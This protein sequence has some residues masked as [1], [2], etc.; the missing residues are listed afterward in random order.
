M[1]RCRCATEKSQLAIHPESKPGS[2]VCVCDGGAQ[3][4]REPEFTEMPFFSS[5][6]SSLQ[7]LLRLWPSFNE[8]FLTAVVNVDIFLWFFS[9]FQFELSTQETLSL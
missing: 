2:S 6:H 5:G 9:F 1:P 3:L 8:R 7:S 4:I